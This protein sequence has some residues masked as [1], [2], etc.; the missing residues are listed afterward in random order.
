MS[1]MLQDEFDYICSLSDVKF[2][3]SE[4]SGFPLEVGIKMQGRYAQLYF[5]GR[6]Q[7]SMDGIVVGVQ[8][9][10][11]IVHYQADSGDSGLH[12]FL[13]FPRAEDGRA[14]FTCVNPQPNSKSNLMAYGE[15]KVV[16][17]W[18]C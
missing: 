16:T 18:I 12:V 9:T 17:P 1:S 2:S 5:N 3:E 4:P 8:K 15:S 14:V 7:G 10:I 6:E 13:T 11:S